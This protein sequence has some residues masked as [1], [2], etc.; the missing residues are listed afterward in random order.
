MI[1]CINLSAAAAAVLKSF[2]RSPETY[3]PGGQHGV[4]HGLGPRE[5]PVLET[6]RCHFAL[7]IN[8]GAHGD[9]LCRPLRLPRMFFLAHPLHPDRLAYR[10]RQHG[11]VLGSIVRLH[12][13]IAAGSLAV[14]DLHL[15]LGKAEQLGDSLSGVE[16]ALRARPD[17]YCVRADVR[18]SARGAD[19]A[20]KLE[21]PAVSRF[22]GPGGARK[23]GAGVPAINYHIFSETLGVLQIIMGLVEAGRELG[24]GS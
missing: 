21:G 20:M 16:R 5:A 24:A 10:A 14:E 7:R 13:S 3:L 2:G 17:G 1:E 11:G 18:H 22:K 8:T 6:P 9:E 4:A 15:N 19:H 23:C 12:P